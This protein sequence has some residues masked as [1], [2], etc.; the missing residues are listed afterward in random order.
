MDNLEGALT[1][2]VFTEGVESGIGEGGAEVNVQ[3]VEESE[4]AVTDVDADVDVDVDVDVDGGRCGWR[5]REVSRCRAPCEAGDILERA[6]D[7]RAKAGLFYRL[8]GTGSLPGDRRPGTVDR[9]WYWVWV[10]CRHGG[11]EDQVLVSDVKLR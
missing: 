9:E 7:W 6:G 10:G 2:R 1:P 8:V 4:F 11:V 5:V 3:G